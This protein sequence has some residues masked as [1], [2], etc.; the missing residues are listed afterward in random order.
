MSGEMASRKCDSQGLS[1]VR[2]AMEVWSDRHGCSG[3]TAGLLIAGRW[4]ESRLGSSAQD[5][6]PARKVRLVF[7]ALIDERSACS[8]RVNLR[9]IT[10]MQK[11]EDPSD[12]QAARDADS[13]WLWSF[14]IWPGIVHQ[15]RDF[16]SCCATVESTV[17]RQ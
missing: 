11:H 9:S 16:D 5:C 1:H 3:P 14:D 17:G 6:P 10:G 2:G 12:R 13:L 15:R 4:S 8:L 7:F